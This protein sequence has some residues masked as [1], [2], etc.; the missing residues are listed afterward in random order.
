MCTLPVRFFGLVA[1]PLFLIFGIASTNGQTS[2]AIAAQSTGSQDS[3]RAKASGQSKPIPVVIFTTW[4]DPREGAFTLNV[5]GGWQVNGGAMRRSAVDVTH[6]VRAGTPDGRVQIFINDADILAHEIPNQLTAMA[7]LREGQVTKG[8]WGGPVLLER[9][10]NGPQ[11]AQEYVRKKI[12]PQADFTGG[13]ELP[14]ETRQM[15]A[16]VVASTDFFTAKPL[17]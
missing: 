3:A 17:I 2:A 7:G 4:R 5:P 8:A 1:A 9:Y 10:R 11:F 14:N 16:Q 15:N 12:C 6:V 13:G